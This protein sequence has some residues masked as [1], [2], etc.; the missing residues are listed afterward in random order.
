MDGEAMILATYKP[1]TAPYG[2]MPFL[3][4]IP[5]ASW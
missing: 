4:G 1:A 5:P 3:V 2:E